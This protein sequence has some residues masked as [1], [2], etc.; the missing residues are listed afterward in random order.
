[1]KVS[2][3]N[4]SFIFWAAVW[5]WRLCDRNRSEKVQTGRLSSSPLLDSYA[6]ASLT[7]SAVAVR[8]ALCVTHS[9]NNR[10]MITFTQRALEMVQFASVAI[11]TKP[12]SSSEAVGDQ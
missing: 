5:F 7:L 9:A 11:G 1:M 10:Q 8:Y 2:G 6:D 4:E 3:R 12:V